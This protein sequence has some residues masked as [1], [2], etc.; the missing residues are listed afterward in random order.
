M[1]ILIDVNKNHSM[2]RQNQIT[3]NVLPVYTFINIVMGSIL[4]FYQYENHKSAQTLHTG[5]KKIWTEKWK[6]GLPGPAGFQNCLQS[7]VQT[8][9][10]WYYLW[11]DGVRFSTSSVRLSERQRVALKAVTA[12]QFCRILTRLRTGV[13]PL[14]AP[15][16]AGFNS[17]WRSARW[18]HPA[19][20]FKS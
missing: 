19:V 12:G 15:T 6:N 11:T 4:R 1:Y 2:G 10:S 13:P 8:L 7:Q 18:R 3:F 17:D 20:S 14:G 16:L 9:A 5:T